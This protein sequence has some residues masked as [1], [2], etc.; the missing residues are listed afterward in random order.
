MSG[1]GVLLDT[2]VLLYLS[3][4]RPLATP[5][6]EAI[7]DARAAGR[8]FVS[9]VSALEIGFLTSPARK[10]PMA[11]QPDPWSWLQAIYASDGVQEVPIDAATAYASTRLPGDL[12]RD[13][14]DRMLIA[15]AIRLDIPLITDDRAI[16]AYAA[17][18]HVDAIA[19]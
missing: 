18:G 8:I 17:L 16:L 9:A 4:G 13:P 11:I 19:C 1:P 12:H 7:G 5:A 14:N 2:C 10:Y 6:T 3:S 15:T